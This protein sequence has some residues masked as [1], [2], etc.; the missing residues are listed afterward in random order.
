[1]RV[2]RAPTLL[3]Q[4][5]GSTLILAMVILGLLLALGIS[6]MLSSAT[7]FRLSGNIQFEEQALNRAEAAIATAEHWLNGNDRDAGFDQ[8][9]A[10]TPYLHPTGHLASMAAPDNNALTMRW[11]DANSLAIQPGDDTGR[12]FIE[13]ISLHVQAQG[14]DLSVGDRANTV[15]NAVNTYLITA[16]GTAARGA[17]RWLQSYYAVPGC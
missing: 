15:C 17:V 1:M 13:R 2:R 9:S 10:A 12:Y 4:Q 7:Q 8:Y 11:S 3:H 6:S 16:R 14:S 5:R